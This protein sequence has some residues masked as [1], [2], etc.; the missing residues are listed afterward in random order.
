MKGLGT[1]VNAA[2]IFLGGAA[3]LLLHKGI[4]QKLHERVMEALALGVIL[5]GL[6]GALKGEKLITHT[7][8]LA[9]YREAVDL[10]EHRRDGSLKVVIHP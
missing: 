10:F 2:A 4:S 7:F 9:D 6:S 3:G 8:D 5:I 1:I